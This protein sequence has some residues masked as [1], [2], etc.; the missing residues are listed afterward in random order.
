MLRVG[1]KRGV[2]A[3]GVVVLTML[4]AMRASADSV[5]SALSSAPPARR[6]EERGPDGSTPLQWAV[7][8]GDV[9]EVKRL[10][11]SGAAVGEANAYGATPMQLAAE[12]AM[13]RSSSCCS[14]PAR[15]SIPR[16]RKGRPR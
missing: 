13:R 15:T 1:G 7:Y 5:D 6:A 12:T 16:M 4:G 2:M 10:I 8:R 9:A 14:T 11:Q 3:A